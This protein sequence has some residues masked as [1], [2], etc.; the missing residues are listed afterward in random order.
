MKPSGVAVRGRNLRKEFGE[1]ESQVLALRGVDLWRFSLEHTVPAPDKQP[2]SVGAEL[3][4]VRQIEN[5]S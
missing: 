5:R 2:I 3:E 4:S 1:G